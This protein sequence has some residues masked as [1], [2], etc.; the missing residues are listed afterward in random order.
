MN[1]TA[2]AALIE[3]YIAKRND[4]RR[5]LA[6]R[7]GNE[8]HAEDIVQ[9]M[10]FRLQRG[11]F[12]QSIENP[13]AFLYKVAFNLARDHHRERQRRVARDCQWV[14]ANIEKLGPDVISDTA[15]PEDAFDAKRR[16][17]RIISAL[18]ELP[19]RCRQVFVLHKLDGL[20]HAQVARRLNI[21]RGMVEKHMTRA[22]KHLLRIRNDGGVP[23]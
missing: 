9:D 5:F 19:P 7:F 20:T 17:A 18:S 21:S 3:A 11:D 4:L 22:L 12:H 2:K 23:S 1:E 14:D 15:P 13:A 8:D 10:F 6:A 16:L